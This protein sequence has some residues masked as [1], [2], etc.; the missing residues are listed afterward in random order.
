MILHL[1]RWLYLKNINCQQWR[2]ETLI[3]DYIIRL[4]DI[5]YYVLYSQKLE[6][7]GLSVYQ[8]N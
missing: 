1:F 8:N 5:I 2:V 7:V 6:T 3:L 4:Q